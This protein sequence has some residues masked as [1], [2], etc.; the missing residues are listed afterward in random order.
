MR[1][2]LGPAAAPR[3]LAA[4]AAGRCPACRAPMFRGAI[5]MHE[6]CPR[7]GVRY[8]MESG[9]WLGATALGCAAGALAGTALLVAELRWDLLED[10]GL[11]PTW[12]IAAMAW[13]PPRSPTG[14]RRAFG[15]RYCDSTSSPA[16]R[17]AVA[18]SGMRDQPP[19]HVSTNLE[20]PVTARA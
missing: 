16:S 8:E 11:P 20:L 3:A 7:C 2:G 1:A 19:A 10:A 18:R 9:A 5:T 15:S 4:G 14:P 17:T 13:S 12:S 6:R